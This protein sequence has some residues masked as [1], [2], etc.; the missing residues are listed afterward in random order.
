MSPRRPK[1]PCNAPHC[2]QLVEA[3]ERYCK[4]H[5]TENN[6]QVKQ[7][8]S[9]APYSRLYDTAPWKR[10]RAM[11]LALDPLCEPCQ[12]EGRVTPATVAHHK[13]E[14]RDGGA[15]LTELDELESM[16]WS[17]HSKEH[18]FKSVTE[19]GEKNQY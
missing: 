6:R 16:C 12:R 1:K 17:C 4:E 15:L 7:R 11:K 3:G 18:G 14:L 2:P 5:K 9:D 19:G 13:E 10:L 8:R